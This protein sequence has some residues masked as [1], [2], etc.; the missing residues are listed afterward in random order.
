MYTNTEIPAQKDAECKEGRNRTTLTVLELM[1][2]TCYRD[3]NTVHFA[4]VGTR[5]RCHIKGIMV[6]GMRSG[7]IRIKHQEGAIA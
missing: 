6:A 2:I 1:F 7:N 4:K 3:D 5:S